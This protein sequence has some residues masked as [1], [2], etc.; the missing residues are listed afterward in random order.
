MQVASEPNA[1][2]IIVVIYDQLG[3]TLSQNLRR[4]DAQD[5]N[6]REAKFQVKMFAITQIEYC[7]GMMWMTK[8]NCVYIIMMMN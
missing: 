4:V 1:C 3:L 5:C 8:K 7:S 6:F 2:G